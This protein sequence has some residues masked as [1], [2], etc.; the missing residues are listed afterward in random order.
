M[1]YFIKYFLL[2]FA[3][4]TSGPPAF[5]LAND[6]MENHALDAYPLQGL[7][8]STDAQSLDKMLQRQVFPLAELHVFKRE[9]MCSIL[10]QRR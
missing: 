10:T 3:D 6:S 1:A 2:V 4:G 9:R 5:V 7:G 8:I